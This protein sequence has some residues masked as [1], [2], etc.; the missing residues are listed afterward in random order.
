MVIS[1]F[2]VLHLLDDGVN[3]HFLECLFSH[4]QIPPSL[5]FLNS[6]LFYHKTSYM[7]LDTKYDGNLVWVS[8]SRCPCK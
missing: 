3:Y 5:L 7:K 2:A 6:F 1:V 4:T 8:N